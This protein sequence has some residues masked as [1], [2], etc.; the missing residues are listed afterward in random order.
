MPEPLIE[1][2]NVRKAFGEQVV[3]DGV[4]LRVEQDLVTTIIGRSGI[5]KSVLLKLV[6]GLLAPDG[7][8]ILYRGADVRNLS[9]AER[10]QFK[11]EVSYMFQNLALFDSMTVYENV[12]L[13]LEEKTRLSKAAIR[14][15]V[16][17]RLEQLDLHDVT[18]KYPS[19]LSGG[20]RKRVALARALITEPRIVLFDEP[21]TGLDPIRKGEVHRM[22]ARY[23]KAFDFTA[24]IV[25]HDIPEVFGISQRVAMLENGR[26]L[27]S[28]TAEA[29]VASED[30]AVRRFIE[31]G[32]NGSPAA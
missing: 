13:P 24:L 18:P 9:R 19:A 10:R 15:R 8:E 27:F 1:L 32:E 17:A 25:S 30:P 4:D 12:A 31:G 3:L 22:I 29:I 6:I 23:Q 26:I 20:M 21:T 2:K 28:G 14:E 16:M 11:R 5:G 7:G